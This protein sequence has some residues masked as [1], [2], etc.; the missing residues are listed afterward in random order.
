[1]LSRVDPRKQRPQALCVCP[2]RELT[3]QNV[4]VLQRMGQFTGIV[5]EH[6]A[7]DWPSKIPPFTAQ[8][9]V[10]TPGRLLNWIS[11]RTLPLADMRML[12]FD[13]ADQMVSVDGFGSDSISIIRACIQA[14]A[15][16]QHADGQVSLYDEHE[17]SCY[18]VAWSAR[19]PWVFASTSYDGRV[20]INH[21]PRNVKYR[22]IL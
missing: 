12:V 10:G 22:I 2:T 3:L 11:R 17:E 21:V 5:V 9:I 6:T 14:G 7:K 16:P 20:A 13:E 4:A 1:M 18:A 19:D 8:I 15:A